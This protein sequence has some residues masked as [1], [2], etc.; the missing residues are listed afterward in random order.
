MN[1]IEKWKN[2]ETKKKLREENKRLKSILTAY[3]WSRFINKKE[4]EIKKFV[5]IKTVQ[6]DGLIDPDDAIELTKADIKANIMKEVIPFIEFSD[7]DDLM[8]SKEIRE[9]LYV[10]KRDEQ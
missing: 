1:L 6:L 9:T 5:C 7:S 8:G 4:S 3:N 10:V 2:R